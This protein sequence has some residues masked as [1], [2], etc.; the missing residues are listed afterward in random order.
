[1]GPE[2]IFPT[3]V[4]SM[5]IEATIVSFNLISQYLI[6]S[7]FHLTPQTITIDFGWIH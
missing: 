4:D 2:A 5:F 7:L 1:M 6:D 3:P